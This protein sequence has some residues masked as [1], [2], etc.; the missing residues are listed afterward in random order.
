MTVLADDRMGPVP[1]AAATTI[2]TAPFVS[3]WAGRPATIV[4]AAGGLIASAGDTTGGVLGGLEHHYA[5]HAGH[6][7][8]TVVDHD[9]ALFGSQGVVLAVALGERAPAQTGPGVLGVFEL[10]VDA[11]L[12]VEAVGG[13]GELPTPTA[14]RPKTCWTR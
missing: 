11:G 6:V 12:Q 13:D 4:K 9:L 1:S 2:A 3:P 10:A 8:V 5:H 14:T 7:A